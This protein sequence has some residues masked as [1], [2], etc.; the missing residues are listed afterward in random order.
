MI[1]LDRRI[2]SSD[3]YQP[4]RSYGIEV[5]LTTIDIGDAAWLGRGAGEFPMPVGVEIKRVG[6]LLSSITSGRLSGYQIPKLIRTYTHVWLVVEGRYRS[7]ID[8]VLETRQ[9][10][11]WGPHSTGKRAFTYREVEAFLT[12]LEVRTGIHVRHTFDRPETAALIATLYHWWTSKTLDEHKAHVALYSPVLDA[13]VLYQPTLTRR[14]AAE[15]PGIGVG[16]SGAVA[17]HFGSP[18]D[19]INASEE[20]W[21]GIPGIGKGIAKKIIEAVIRK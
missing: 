15:L 8:G 6:D 16:R 13:G 12:T 1:L 4:L 3:L 5:A 10:A 2:G 19:M 14:I 9:G 18:R 7:G 11:V 20:E 21:I 17:D